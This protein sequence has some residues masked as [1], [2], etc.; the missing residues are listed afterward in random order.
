MTWKCVNTVL[1]CAR[2]V[3]KMLGGPQVSE[4][5]KQRIVEL[6][7]RGKAFERLLRSYEPELERFQKS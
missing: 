6:R 3:G 2:A 7:A 5:T 1:A 4:E